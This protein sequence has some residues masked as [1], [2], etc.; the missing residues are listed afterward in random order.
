MT[1]PLTDG[2]TILGL[3]EQLSPENA[4]WIMAIVERMHAHLFYIPEPTNTN[5]TEAQKAASEELQWRLEARIEQMDP[6]LDPISKLIRAGMAE[7]PAE[8]PDKLGNI[9]RKR[10]SERNLAKL[11]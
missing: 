8:L 5:P 10:P 1:P 3:T 2:T 7:L 11:R 4:L 6:N 9:E